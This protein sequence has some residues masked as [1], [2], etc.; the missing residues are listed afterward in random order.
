MSVHAANR[1]GERKKLRKTERLLGALFLCIVRKRDK[2]AKTVVHRG[3]VTTKQ[4]LR[5][6]PYYFKKIS[7]L[8]TDF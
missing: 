2:I 7:I 1:A 4:F 3:V 8:K 6:T 5:S